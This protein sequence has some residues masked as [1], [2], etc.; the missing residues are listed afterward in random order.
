[1]LGFVGA[2]FTLASYIVEGGSSK[3][4]THIKRLAFW[5][6]GGAAR[7]AG[8]AGRQ[9]RRLR[10]VPGVG[11]PELI[12]YPYPVHALLGKLADN[13][14]DYMRFQVRGP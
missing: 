13:I 2:P 6:A 7:A 11:N 5:A 14:A 4:Y 8:Q 1:M 3:K 9:H 10:A 12:P